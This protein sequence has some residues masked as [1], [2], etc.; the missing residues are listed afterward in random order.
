MS[1][2]AATT[3]ATGANPPPV[4]ELVLLQGR[5]SQ[6]RSVRQ[7]ANFVYSNEGRLALGGVALAAAAAGLGGQAVAGAM[8]AADMEEE[9]DQLR[10]WVDGQPVQAWVWRAPFAEGDEVQVVASWTGDHYEGYAIA[11]PADRTVA[12]YPHLSR[13]RVAHWRNALRWGA[14]GGLG[15]AAIA[16]VFGLLVVFISGTGLSAGLL[17]MA[18]VAGSIL[19]VIVLLI[20][21]LL[22]RQ[23]MRFVRPAEQIFAKFGWRSPASVD[24][25]KTTR[26]Q[27]K[28]DDDGELGAFYFRY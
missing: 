10:F 5:V 23:W 3:S 26:R 8:H 17:G 6:Y 7:R 1:T 15:A 19:T 18:A 11:R 20:S 13:G 22:A 9:A 21:L 4:G 28:P 25:V 27:R 12:L 2:Q 16:M 24:L 14:L